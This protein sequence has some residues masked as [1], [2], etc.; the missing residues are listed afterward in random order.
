MTY[1]LEQF[2]A[3]VEYLILTLG[4]PGLA[5]IM[6]A[7]NLFPPIPSEVVLPFAGSLVESGQLGLLGV[8]VSSTLGATL[9]TGLF[10]YL[11]QRLGEARLRPLKIAGLH[12]C[13]ARPMRSGSAI[14]RGTHKGSCHRHA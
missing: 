9:G 2:R 3:L 8:L 13:H 1:L 6:F 5:L 14:C 7:E 11:G 10:Y 12:E 4:Y